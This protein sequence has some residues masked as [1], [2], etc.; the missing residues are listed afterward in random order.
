MV[1][2]AGDIKRRASS[3]LLPFMLSDWSIMGTWTRSLIYHPIHPNSRPD[4]L[5][6]LASRARHFTNTQSHTV[7]EHYKTRSKL[8]CHFLEITHIISLLHV[9]D[10]KKK[11]GLIYFLKLKKI[12]LLFL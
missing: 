10:L 6:P 1:M 12:L 5:W 3:V 9:K 11:I 8:S 2:S 4:V 7:V